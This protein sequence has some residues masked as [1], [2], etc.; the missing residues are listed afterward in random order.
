MITP[1]LKNIIEENTIGFVA[2]VTPD[3]GPHVSPKATMV[4]LD[5]NHI[6]F[7]D[8]RSPDTVRNIRV[9]PRVEICFIDIFRRIGC[10]LKGK[11]TYHAKGSAG[12]EE[13]RVN[14]NRWE[15][16]LDRVEGIVVMEVESAKKVISPA[17]DSG[18]SEASLIEFWLGFYNE[19]HQPEEA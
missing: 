19:L 11:A 15:P 14:F 5:G 16:L 12:F 6:A 17:Y 1:E 10:R 4:C 9:N 7:C 3:G 18:Q 13:L 8:I 2:T